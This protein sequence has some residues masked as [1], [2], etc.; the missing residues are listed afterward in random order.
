MNIPDLTFGSE[1][2]L[3]ELLCLGLM[4]DDE[5][6]AFTDLVKSGTL[7]WGELL[8]QALRHKML[9][10][11]AHHTLAVEP[12]HA[13]PRRVQDQ[14][15]TVLDLNRHKRTLWYREADKVIKFFDEQGVQVLGRKDVAFESM[16]YGEQ[17]SRRLGDIDLLIEPKDREAVIAGL[18]KLGYQTGLFNWKTKQLE[19][20][21]RKGMLILRMN[22]DHVPV[23]SRL[24][25]DPILHYLEVD[26][27][28]SLTWHG[29]TYNV[30]LDVAMAS[31]I[32][33]PIA[34]FSDIEIPCLP[35]TFQFIGTV[36]HLFREAWFERWIEWEQDVDLTKF[37]DVIRMWRTYNDILATD[38][39]AQSLK[40]FEI[41]E[42]MAW[43]LEH[44]DRTFNMDI[45]ATL[46]LK[47]AV[48]ETKLFS[49]SASGNQLLQWRGSMRE[50]LYS[51]NRQG[52][53][54]GTKETA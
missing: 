52:L 2:A 17:G 40:D 14:F 3:M 5:Q 44:L 13:V 8:E 1:W 4:T 31:I 9:P 29:S 19:P 50:R 21:S 25:D 6:Q 7:D 37:S 32:R 45:S 46:D 11:L 34:G 33:Q 10:L 16:L 51:K 36:L 38:A 43:V 15:R 28:N 26:F 42:P 22:P 41:V 53:F 23:H 27:A 49:G 20:L 54:V 48:D 18:P 47:N 12:G 30:P 35:P 39:F 24:I